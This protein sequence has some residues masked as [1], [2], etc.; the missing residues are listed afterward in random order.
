VVIAACN[1]HQAMKKLLKIALIAFAIFASILLLAFSWHVW[2]TKYHVPSGEGS[3]QSIS[4]NGRF[5]VTGYLTKGLLRFVPT[6]PG[7][8]SSGPGVVV[9]RENQTGQILETAR[10]DSLNALR[11]G[12][13][14]EG[15]SVYVKFI[16]DWSLPPAT[17][18]KP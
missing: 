18:S 8:G 5:I 15:N 13:M 10:I 9:L 17:D 3:W 11:E 6:A 7:D 14:W 2:E 4:P 1:K 12:V 16:G